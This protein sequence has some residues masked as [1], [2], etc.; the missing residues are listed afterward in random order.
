[1]IPTVKTTLVVG[2]DLAVITQKD[3]VGD[4][5]EFFGNSKKE[6]TEMKIFTMRLGIALVVAI[7]LVAIPLDDSATLAGTRST[8]DGPTCENFLHGTV[9][10]DR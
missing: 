6:F 5:T 2:D 10:E 8:T 1:M 3:Q 4:I 9:Q 7:G